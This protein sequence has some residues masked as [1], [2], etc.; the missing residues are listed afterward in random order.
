MHVSMEVGLRCIVSYGEGKGLGDF[1]YGRLDSILFV[2]W[3]RGL[4]ERES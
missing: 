3:V 4:R 2:L 1:F